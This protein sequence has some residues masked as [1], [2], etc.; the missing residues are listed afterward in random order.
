M[1]YD[2]DGI[3][4]PNNPKDIQY[5][6]GINLTEMG[7]PADDPILMTLGNKADKM[8]W[9]GRIYERGKTLAQIEADY[10]IPLSAKKRS[11][12]TLT[13]TN[14]TKYSGKWLFANIKTKEKGGNTSSFELTLTFLKGSSYIVM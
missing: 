11:T 4:L 1:T 2:V 5:D 13:V 6:E 7:I 12:V 14:R 3:T 9:K 10:I 8:I